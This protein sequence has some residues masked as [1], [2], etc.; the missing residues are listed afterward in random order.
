MF[1]WLKPK[2]PTARTTASLRQ[3]ATAASAAHDWR[4]AESLYR[5]IVSA[6]SGNVDALYGL[7][8]ALYQLDRPSDALPFLESA[9]AHTNNIAPYHYKLGNALKDLG[10][11]SEAVSHYERALELDPHHAQTYNNLGAALQMMGQTNTAILAYR[12]ALAADPAL[13]PAHQNLTILLHQSGELESGLN[14]CLAWLRLTPESADAWSHLGMLYRRLGRTAEALGALQ[15]GLAIAP[16]SAALLNALGNHYDAENKL[17]EAVSAYLRAVSATPESS[18]IHANLANAMLRRGEV[19]EAIR[20]FRVALELDPHNDQAARLLLMAV[21]YHP[22]N[23]E[24]LYRE[25]V[26]FAKVFSVASPALFKNKP[27][28]TNTKKLRIGYVSSDF[29]RHPV[30]LNMQPIIHSH[31]RLAFEIYLYPHLDQPD[32]TSEWFKAH[33]D[34]WRP[35]QGLNDEAAARL[36]A[37]DGID[38]LVFLAGRFDRNRPLIACYRPAPIQVSMHDPATSGLAEM[39][40]LIADRVLAPADTPELFTE[41]VVHLPTFY[42]HTTIPDSPAITALPA[43]TRGHIT[44][45]SFNNPGKLSE[46]TI[47]LWARILQAIPNARL[48]LKYWGAFGVNSIQERFREAFRGHGITDNRLVLHGEA[49]VRGHHLDGYSEIDVALDPFPFTGSTT[50]FEALWM[51]VPVVTLMGDRMVGRWSAAMLAKVGLPGLIARN[52]QEY[53]DIAIQLV[54]KLPDLA[55]TRSMLR[56]RVARS[57]LCAVEKRTRQLERLYRCMWATYL[58]KSNPENHT[59]SVI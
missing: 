31:D 32:Q 35:I 42:L 10:R 7:G 55:E 52:E 56:E 3:E 17:D 25:H 15:R 30:A 46:G 54:A 40:Y 12:Q 4:R 6:D 18:Q 22:M 2:S 34:A 26:A 13:V 21:L 51:G 36:I 11:L 47:A 57:P 28:R 58:Q 41:R 38:I 19:S 20:L 9:I 1:D 59:P 5:K 37:E 49:S 48:V 33:C 45:G 24:R 14:A 50:T 8:D 23:P 39:D 53:V 27:D 29:R 16:D 43:L 44:F